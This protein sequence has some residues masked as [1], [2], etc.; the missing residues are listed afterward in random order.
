MFNNNRYENL[1]ISTLR[2]GIA[3]LYGVVYYTL[4]TK[5]VATEK[6]LIMSL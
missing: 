5:N 1:I 2:V 4:A 3:N 6:V